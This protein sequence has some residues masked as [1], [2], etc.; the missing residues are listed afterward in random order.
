MHFQQEK[1]E[2]ALKSFVD[3]FRA[4]PSG[5]LSIRLGIAACHFKLHNYSV[6][7][8]AYER[9]LQLDPDN[10]EAL[11][12]LAALDFAAADPRIG[13]PS[14]L[15]NLQRAYAL[16]PTSAPV[17]NALSTFALVRGDYAT[18]IDLAEAAVRPHLLRL[19]SSGLQTCF[20]G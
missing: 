20:P 17:L 8:A 6:A 13:V 7:Q 19:P 16:D 4:H 2:S 18:S 11:A 1:Y 12:G 15:A 3:A 14:G 10:A 5:P 9:V